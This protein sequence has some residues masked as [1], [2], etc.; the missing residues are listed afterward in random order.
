MAFHNIIFPEDYSQGAVGGPEFRTTVVSTGSGFEQ[1]NVD[2]SLA[3]CR[4]D[5]SRLLYDP[6]AR[7]ATIAF[8]RARQGR[9]HSFLFKDWADY[10]TGMQWNPS[11]KVLDHIGAHNFTTG[12]GTQTVFQIFKVYDSGGF[13]ERRKI[14]RV[15]SPIRVY[16]N[17]TLQTQPGQCSVNTS[18]GIITFVSAPANGAQI[19]WSG[20]FYV[21]V[22]FD[23]DA[24]SME[25][26]SATVGDAPLPIVE[27]RE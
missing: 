18:S 9:A 10:F 27:I 21:P 4:W 5:L 14:T 15:K 23:T 17:G 22:R 19:G 7:D 12:T 1:R 25:Y 20:E 8:F 6:A 26:V 24:L 2:W 11:T 3:R 13:Q 16:V